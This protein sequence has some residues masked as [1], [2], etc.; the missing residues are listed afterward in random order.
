MTVRKAI[1]VSAFQG[2]IDWETV[3]EHVD[4]AIIRAGAGQTYVDDDFAGNISECN[5]IGLPVGVYFFSYARTEK[6][7]VS[8]AQRCLSLIRPYKVELPVFLD[9]EYDSLGDD[10]SREHVSSIY[11]SF[12]ETI[13]A[14]GYFASF[15][16]NKDFS[17]KYLDP[18]LFDRFDCWWALWYE[19][20]DPFDPPIESPNYF[21]KC[22][23]WQYGTGNIPGISGNVDVDAVYKD[24]VGMIRDCGLN[25]LNDEPLTLY[26]DDIRRIL[27][28]IGKE[29]GL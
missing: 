13:E 9:Y 2:K 12:L 16:T 5:R 8:E 3:A 22:G 14:G 21:P 4:Y 25:R 1:D 23:M 15:Y 18:A 10:R 20:A 11:R 17:S 7:A 28:Y 6:E 19:G 27:D 24:Y 26:K 29:I